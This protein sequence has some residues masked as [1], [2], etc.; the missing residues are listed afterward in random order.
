MVSQ[1]S[2]SQV[3]RSFESYW[4]Y[5]TAV[6]KWVFKRSI[7]LFF[8]NSD[9]HLYT[10]QTNLFIVRNRWGTE[11][12]AN[13]VNMTL[14]NAEPWRS[15]GS[16]EFPLKCIRNKGQ[17]CA[18]RRLKECVTH[19]GVFCRILMKPQGSAKGQQEGK[20][21]RGGITAQNKQNVYTV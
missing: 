7:V 2:V 21:E 17:L 14:R 10:Q 15:H 4:T 20:M 11:T 18:V 6:G 16:Y 12:H 5:S 9:G 3:K 8:T 19:W 13:Y 1:E